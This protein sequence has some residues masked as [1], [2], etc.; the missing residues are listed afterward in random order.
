MGETGSGPITLLLIWAHGAPGPTGGVGA[1]RDPEGGLRGARSLVQSPQGEG[2]DGVGAHDREVPSVS[3]GQ[4]G[5][6]M[7][8]GRSLGSNV[9]TTVFG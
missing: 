4:N 8:R 6:G 3:R 2:G 5:L 9:K 7:L 1:A